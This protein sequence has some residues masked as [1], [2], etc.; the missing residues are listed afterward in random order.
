MSWVRSSAA[1]RFPRGILIRFM[2]WTRTKMHLR[3]SCSPMVLILK[4]KPCYIFS[5]V[6]LFLFDFKNVPAP[7]AVFWKM[8]S[9]W[10]ISS[11]RSVPFNIHLILILICLHILNMCVEIYFNSILPMFGKFWDN[12]R[13]SMK[14]WRQRDWKSYL[15]IK[16]FS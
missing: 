7:F 15:T 8:R 6:K 10:E 12:A 16:N 4:I 3:Y 14:T 11:W 9:D 13:E 1:K 5:R 2:Q